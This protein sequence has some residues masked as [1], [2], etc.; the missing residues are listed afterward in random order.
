MG[1]LTVILLLSFVTIGVFMCNLLA[2][3]YTCKFIEDGEYSI[4]HVFCMIVGLPFTILTFIIWCLQVLI[5]KYDHCIKMNNKSVITVITKFL[6]KKR[7]VS[8]KKHE[9]L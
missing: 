7:F 9:N 1:E 8:C 4:L 2:I 6:T 3:E 5:D